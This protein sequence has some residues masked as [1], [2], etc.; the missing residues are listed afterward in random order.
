M[1]LATR[2]MD[3]DLFILFSSRVGVMG[4]PGQANH[5]A[6]NAF[7]DQLAAHRRTIGL[8]GQTIAW[9]AWSD[10]GEAAEQKE[11]IER[12]RAALGG[13][14]FTPQQGI[15]ALDRL[16]RQDVV[17]AVVMSMDWAVFQEAV[18]ER[19]ALLEDLFSVTADP[20]DDTPAL[21]EDLIHR[22]RQTPAVERENLL[23]AFLQQ[24]LQ[25]V[26][27][28][29]NEPSPT[30]GFFDLG[31]DSLMAVELR[32]RLNRAFADE[33]VA[34]NTVVFDYPDIAA[35]AGHLT[36]ELGELGAAFAITPPPQPQIIT[37]ERRSARGEDDHIAVVG[38]ACRFPGAPD[39]RAY[40]D[41]LMSGGSAVTEGR[42]DTGPWSGVV[43]DPA[44]EDDI[45]RRGGF[46][47]G[48]G[49]FDADFF[50]IRPIEPRVMDPRHRMLLETCWH[51]LEDAGIDP[52]SLQSTQA[53]VYIGLGSSEYRDLVAAIDQDYNL[54][55]TSGSIAI[56]RVAFALGLMGPAMAMDMTCASSLVAIHQA[57]TSLHNGEVTL[58]L[59][60]DVHSVLSP[61]ITRFMAEYGMLSAGGLCRTFD[62]GADGFVRGEGCGVIVLKRLCDAEADADRIWGVIRGS[63]VN[64]N[65]ASAALTVPNGKAQEQVLEEALLRAGVP[66]AEVDF[67]E[68]HATGSQ[69]GNPIEVHAPASAYGKDRQAERPLLLGTAKT[70]IGHLEAAAGIAGIIKTLLAMKRGMIPKHLHF[71]R[72]N[73]HMD[74]HRLPVEVTSEAMDWPL[75]TERPPQAGVSAFALSGTNAHVVV[76]GYGPTEGSGDGNAAFPVPLGPARRVVPRVPAPVPEPMDTVPGRE[77]RLLPLSRKSPSALR[78]LA[79]GYLSWLDGQLS[80][81]P[82]AD[83]GP[84]L[85]DMAWTAGVGRSHFAHRKGIVFDSAASL[86]KGL[87]TITELNGIP[88][89]TPPKLAMVLGGEVD[90]WNGIGAELYER[91]S[92][93]RAVLD[94]CD[95]VLQGERDGSLLELILGSSGDPA[96]MHP[97]IC[98][99]ECALVALWGS[100]G[101]R[102]NIVLGIGSGEVAAAHAAGIFT[103]EEGLVFAARRG[104]LIGRHA[105]L[106]LS[107]LEQALSDAACTRPVIPLICGSSGHLADATLDASYWHRK[108]RAPG[109]ID[110]CVAMLA[111]AGVGVIIEAG[112]GR[113]VGPKIIGAWPGANVGAGQPAPGA[114]A[115]AVLASH[116]VPSDEEALGG[117]VFAEAVAR[118]NE[119]GFPVDFAGLFAGENRCRISIPAYPFQRR[120]YWFRES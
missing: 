114:P 18:E 31:M 87:M 95:Q 38:M 28:L 64:Q 111:D 8:P 99:L 76:E 96:L 116:R 93:V 56:G 1:H 29:P 41:L 55:G 109:N 10:I 90:Q 17:H 112:P 35:L 16:V 21:A 66:P 20:A 73:P 24:K 78:D 45:L 98:A 6:A 32:N 61:A 47:E 120:H 13:R 115:P 30:V 3:L 97:A 23:V 43:G 52:D 77:V 65:G 119:A 63:A 25:A 36:E 58:A 44:A 68:V 106:T 85:S 14:W 100:V 34:S 117:W 107:D 39:L 80:G 54:L 86:R 33:Y 2:D 83:A 9:G 82:A 19:P 7:L 94:R 49:Q 84:L 60:G 81:P 74:W 101:L 102:P 79:K 11:R 5:A 88:P 40:W 72:P 69:L 27:R 67:L 37:E 48:L 91:E 108:V 89:A 51:S 104:A 118:A 57:V 105:D 4:N 26:L 50:G 42:Q 15:R 75:T 70:N 113:V 12:R 46:I 103:L 110:R 62:A 22:L 53:G 71:E 92:V 59:A